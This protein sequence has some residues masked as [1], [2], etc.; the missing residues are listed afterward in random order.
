MTGKSSVSEM[1]GWGTQGEI[2]WDPPRGATV[3]LEHGETWF[4]LEYDC[5]DHS[6]SCSSQP[7]QA[8]SEVVRGSVGFLLRLCSQMQCEVNSKN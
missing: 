7:R 3:Y 5:K 6:G 2:I 8:D 1:K 4:A